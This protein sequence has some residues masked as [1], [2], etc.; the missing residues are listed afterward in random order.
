MASA[1]APTLSTDSVDKASPRCC[2]PAR[3]ELERRTSNTPSRRAAAAPSGLGFRPALPRGWWRVS[4]ALVILPC[5]LLLVPFPARAASSTNGP[6]TRHVIVVENS[7]HMKAQR[8]QAADLVSRLMLDGFRRRI[9]VG[10]VVELWVIEN[11]INTNALPA[12]R[13]HP[14]A[15]VDDSNSAFRFLRSLKSSAESVDLKTIFPRLDL[16][17]PK[18]PQLL[19]YLV[20]SGV[21]PIEGTP[22][23]DQINPIFRDHHRRLSEAGQ[24]FV[25]V[26]AAQD[27]E[28]SGHGVTPGDRNPYIPLFPPREKETDTSSPTPSTNTAAPPLQP[29]AAATPPPKPMTVDEIAI[30]MR[31]A[32]LERARTSPPPATVS[33]ATQAVTSVEPAASVPQASE[34]APEPPTAAPL[35]TNVPLDPAPGRE[36]GSTNPLSPPAILTN[37]RAPLEPPS[38]GPKPPPATSSPDPADL[39]TP[40]ERQPVQAEPS[41]PRADSAPP[42]YIPPPREAPPPALS[43]WKDLLVGTALLAAAGA[44][45]ILLIRQVRRRPQESLIS[46]S[47]GPL[48]DSSRRPPGKN[49]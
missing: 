27:G 24:P 46:E 30:K 41:P 40:T 37:T 12:F 34:P 6:P 38:P 35:A 9:Q 45:A 3:M 17:N 25:T 21:D 39:D 28:W 31:E 15:A 16:P 26:L 5:A 23:D 11:D 32:A 43:P 33:V 2:N 44:L 14:I 1:I 19:V 48:R 20:T 10:E 36:F 49:S 4:A 29:T 42:V 47:F 7:A 18:I 22:F 8:E 13:W